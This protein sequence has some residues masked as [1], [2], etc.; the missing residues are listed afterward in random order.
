[1]KLRICLIPAALLLSVTVA[2][3]PLG[4]A[5][6]YQ[7][8]LKDSGAPANCLFDL[9]ACLY[10]GLASASPIV[11]AADAADVPVQAGLFTTAFDFGAA[12]F[13]GEARYLELRVRPGASI[14]GYTTLAP[15]QLL[16]ATPEA[17]RA[18]SSSSA[19]WSGLSGVPAGFADGIDNNSGGTVTSI[20]AGTGL[21]GGTIIGSG[22]LGIATGGVGNAQLGADAVD[23]S[24][25]AN[26]AVDAAAIIDA[27]VT[28]PKI[29]AGAVGLVQINTAQ[30]QAR[31]GGSCALGTYLRGINADGGVLC[32]ELTGVNAFAMLDGP[33]NQAG[34]YLDIA[35]GSDG[36]PVIAYFEGSTRA[37]KVV[38]CGNTACAGNVLATT[39]DDPA[40]QVGLYPSIAVGSTGL[41]VIS[42]YDSTARV[43]KVAQCYLPNCGDSGSGAALPTIVDGGPNQVGQQSSIAIGLDGLPVIAYLDATA[44]ALRV[45]KC[46]NTAC[47]GAPTITTVDD[48]VNLV[49]A[50]ASLAIGSDGVPVISH[51][52]RTANALRVT[53][54][55]NAAC[56]G[57]ATSTNVDD[58]ANVITFQTAIAIGSDGL[59]LISYYDSTANTLKVAHCSDVA[60]A[61]PATLT[62]VDNPANDVGAYTSIAIGADGLAVISYHDA[63]AGAL[64]VAKCTNT[65]CTAAPILSTVDNPANQ[66]GFGTA[67]TIGADGLP[68]IAYFDVTAS[69]LRYVKCGTRSCR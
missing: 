14:G 4:T 67:I 34:L 65:A 26:N 5:L 18:A 42:Y 64:K 51:I 40:N 69:A 22:T 6:S 29:A 49:G 59:P 15:R 24:K 43:L 27:N 16:R 53:R 56:T 20:A 1:M 3:A 52:D 28:A 9:Q 54:C 55:A 46:S 2:A 63:T 30:V 36:L 37:L 38:H 13:A 48:P 41:P 10:D 31:I 62:V 11:C 32:G 17:L 33:P 12:P 50:Y 19:P 23:A 60:C 68:M 35:M 8:Q 21:S 61:T 57:S 58:P 45:A 47:S 25:L 44:N 7:G 66:V 39:V